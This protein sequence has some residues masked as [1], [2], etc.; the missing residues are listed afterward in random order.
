MGEKSA[1]TTILLAVRPFSLRCRLVVPESAM[2]N[3]AVFIVDD[4]D[5]FS[6]AIARFLRA[7]GHETRTFG[8]A[9]EFLLQ[10]RPEM[11]GCLLLDLEMPGLNGLELQ[12]N[13][14][15]AGIAMPIVFLTGHG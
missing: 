5:S 11:R 3:P 12:E 8:S 1:C 13:M 9:R 4:D 15:G 2:A 6:R 14:I 10:L 7:S